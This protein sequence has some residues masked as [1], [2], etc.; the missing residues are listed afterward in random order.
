LASE[1]ADIKKSAEKAKAAGAVLSE[2]EGD[3]ASLKRDV[4]C[5]KYEMKKL[6]SVTSEVPVVQE[7][8]V[9]FAPASDVEEVRQE[10][11]DAKDEVAALASEVAYIKN[12]A[13]EAKAAGAV[14][15]E[16]EGDF[17]SLKRD[18]RCLKHLSPGLRNSL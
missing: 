5:L 3:F 7:R 12:A 13:G 10:A 17:A 1:V 8:A 16:V 15:S 9:E 6:K 14:L 18:V 4:R 11:K 2:V